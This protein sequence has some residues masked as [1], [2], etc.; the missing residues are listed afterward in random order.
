MK[1]YCAR[2]TVASIVYGP[3]LGAFLLGVLTRK[4]T[5]AGVIAGM[6]TSAIAMAAIWWTTKLAWT[7]YVLVGA[8][9][10]VAIGMTVS[11][12]RPR[13]VVERAA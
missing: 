6:T 7:W 2:L 9:I 11:Y 10:C 4:A 8:L 13:E 5:A 3:M 12:A 1:R